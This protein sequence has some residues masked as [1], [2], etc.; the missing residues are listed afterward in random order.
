MDLPQDDTLPRTIAETV[1][2]SVRKRWP[3]ER[4]R[5]D[6]DAYELMVEQ[7]STRLLVY[8][9]NC[10][11]LGSGGVSAKAGVSAE[12]W[13]ETM[14]NDLRENFRIESAKGA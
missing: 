8:A 10:V 12:Q 5:L 13:C 14:A 2:D 3:R 9:V 1:Q 7:V 4:M 6:D 11:I